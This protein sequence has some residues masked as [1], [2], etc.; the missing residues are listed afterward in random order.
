[1]QG[2]RLLSRRN[3]GPQRWQR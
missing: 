1:M 3:Q 2:G